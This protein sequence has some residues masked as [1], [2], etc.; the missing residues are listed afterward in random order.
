M[1]AGALEGSPA[2]CVAFSFGL[3]YALPCGLDVWRS[4]GYI[5]DW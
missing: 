5:F 1:I 4:Y 2:F 3:L